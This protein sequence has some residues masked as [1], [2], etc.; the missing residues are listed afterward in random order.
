M[1]KNKLLLAGVIAAAVSAPVFAGGASSTDGFNGFYAGGEVGRD[2][3]T[4]NEKESATSTDFAYALRGF[5]AGVVGGYG[6]T[7][8]N[9][10][11]LGAEAHANISN[12]DDEVGGVKTRLKYTYGVDAIPGY[13]LSDNTMAYGRVG[14]ERGKFEAKDSTGAKASDNRNG[15][16][17]GLGLQTK[18]ADQIAV[19]GEYDYTRFQKKDGNLFTSNERPTN[20]AF[21]VGLTYYFG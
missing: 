14:F 3:V 1:R 2:V 6:Q 20:N 8:D 7:F 13:M 10:Y 19:R 21:K 11:Y 5:D 12:A 9:T 4:I 18:V 16:R 17:V 15:L